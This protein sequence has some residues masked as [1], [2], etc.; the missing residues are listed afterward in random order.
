MSREKKLL[1]FPDWLTRREL[2]KSNKNN[3]NTDETV[4]LMETETE[5]L[6]Y[7]PNIDDHANKQTL[8]SVIDS[9]NGNEIDSHIQDRHTLLH[10]CT[11]SN[12]KWE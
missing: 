6:P 12:Y 10:F 9:M 5:Y 4:S 11:F 1:I 7:L 8:N 2:D 3:K